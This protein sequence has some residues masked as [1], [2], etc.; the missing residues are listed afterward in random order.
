MSAAPVS[1]RRRAAL[2][3]AEADY[4]A[5]ADPQQSCGTCS[6]FRAPA[7][8]TLVMGHIHAE[9]TCAYWAASLTKIPPMLPVFQGPP[10]TQHAHVR[11]LVLDAQGRLLQLQRASQDKQ[12]L[13]GGQWESISGTVG[14]D[15][16]PKGETE[17]EAIQ[18][19]VE[20][21]TGYAG[22]S[23]AWEQL[24]PHVWLV[25]LPPGAGAP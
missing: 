14:D 8:C 13:G 20:E 5:A 24:G 3:Q 16:A 11:A 19:E 22:A 4:R 6:M 12:P 1:I 9:D 7:S 17:F 15:D 23:L 2:T 18:R 21:E 25:R 10:Y